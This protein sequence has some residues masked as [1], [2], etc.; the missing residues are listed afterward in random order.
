MILVEHILETARKRLVTV[1][2]DSL[3]C[4]AA[5]I[6]VNPETPLIVVCDSGGVAVGVISRTD[7]VKVLAQ[8]RAN[9]FGTSAEAMMTRGVLSFQLQ[10]PLQ[11]VWEALNARSLRCAP[12]LD[13]EG[14]PQGILHA[15]D[16]ATAL[17]DEV[18]Y[19]ELLLRDYV[20][21][22]GYQ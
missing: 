7:V 20:L 21:G 14:R 1:K 19:E 17:I 16:L 4:D 12:I 10:Q 5:A 22:V 8:A 18:T 13:A 9:A 15:R 6:L 11:K 2:Q 3:V